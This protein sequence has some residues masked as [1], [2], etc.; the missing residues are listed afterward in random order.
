MRV[1]VP[2]IAAIAAFLPSSL[3]IDQEGPNAPTVFLENGP[4]GVVQE[5]GLRQRKLKE[6]VPGTANYASCTYMYTTC[7]YNAWKMRNIC[8][9]TD[10]EWCV[11]PKPGTNKDGAD[12]WKAIG[13]GEIV[14]GGDYLQMVGAVGNICS[15]R[16][17]SERTGKSNWDNYGY[18]YRQ[19]KM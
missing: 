1:V 3:A 12:Y 15:S 19:F 8:T 17:C 2:L 9:V 6:T 18:G 7:E 16:S 4:D 10:Y 5:S 11:E 13:D 14:F